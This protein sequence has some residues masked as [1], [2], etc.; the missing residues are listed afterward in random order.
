MKKK[1]WPVRCPLSRHCQEICD[2]FNQENADD[3]INCPDERALNR[4][5]VYQMELESTA[6]KKV[7]RK[8][9]RT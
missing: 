5:K 6:E 1:T 9:K 4:E 2:I 8:T 3:S 7:A